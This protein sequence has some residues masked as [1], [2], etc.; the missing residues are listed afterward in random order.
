VR[1]SARAY[2]HLLRLQFVN[3]AKVLVLLRVQISPSIL[4][5]NSL[6]LAGAA[7]KADGCRWLLSSAPCMDPSTI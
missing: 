1:L 6:L 5:D 7:S 3:P 2:R 4:P